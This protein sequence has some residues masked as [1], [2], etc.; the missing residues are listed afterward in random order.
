MKVSGV[1]PRRG[2]GKGRG[3]GKSENLWGEEPEKQ[4]NLWI[5]RKSY[6]RGSDLRSEVYNLPAKGGRD[7][8]YKKGCCEKKKDRKYVNREEKGSW[9][10]MTSNRRPEGFK[11]TKS[12]LRRLF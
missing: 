4:V 5:E 10:G 1:K 6:M 7:V 12:A 2:E 3:A 9:I 11:E 8:S